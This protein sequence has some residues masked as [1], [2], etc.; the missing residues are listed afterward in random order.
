MFCEDRLGMN[1]MYSAQGTCC[2]FG[3]LGGFSSW[4]FVGIRVAIAGGVCA[5]CDL[6][7]RGLRCADLLS[8]DLL[9]CKRCQFSATGPAGSCARGRWF[10]STGTAGQFAWRCPL[11][12]GIEA[13]DSFEVR[14]MVYRMSRPKSSLGGLQGLI[15][16]PTPLKPGSLGPSSTTRALNPKP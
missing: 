2:E 10:S 3:E 6:H 16:D 13:L 4:A 5:W 8:N 14:R 12:S 7:L 9:R 11:H 15:W 1:L